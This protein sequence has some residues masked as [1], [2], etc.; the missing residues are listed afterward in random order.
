LSTPKEQE[1][2]IDNLSGAAE[3]TLSDSSSALKK[4]TTALASATGDQASK[5]AALEAKLSGKTFGC[6]CLVCVLR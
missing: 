3:K 6:Y 4:N 2:S 1:E 5:V